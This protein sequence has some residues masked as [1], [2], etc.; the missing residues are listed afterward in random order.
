MS[1]STAKA[2]SGQAKPIGS[3]TTAIATR[4]SMCPPTNLCENETN[5]WHLTADKTARCEALATTP[6]EKT[7][8]HETAVRADSHWRETRLDFG[9]PKY[10]MYVLDSAQSRGQRF[11]YWHTDFKLVSAHA[12]IGRA[13][14]CIGSRQLPSLP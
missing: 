5:V 1:S 2:G 12:R 10:S 13:T 4:L 3:S 8:V 14:S 6:R 7:Q 11:T 9:P